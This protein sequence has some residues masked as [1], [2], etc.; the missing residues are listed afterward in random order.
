M[1]LLAAGVDWHM[2]NLEDSASVQMIYRR[3]GQS[4]E[5]SVTEGKTKYQANDNFGNTV[6]RTTDKTFYMRVDKLTLSGSITEPEEGDTLESVDPQ[7]RIVYEALPMGNLDL[8]E[9]DSTGQKLTIHTK[10]VDS[11]P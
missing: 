7:G 5:V 3:G 4:L 11:E 6:T 8:F 1:N 2:D 10:I 9:I